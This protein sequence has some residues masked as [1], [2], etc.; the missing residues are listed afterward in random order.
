MDSA[1]ERLLPVDPPLVAYQADLAGAH[2]DAPFGPEDGLWLLAAELV[3]R[4]AATDPAMA[5]RLDGDLARL[6][7]EASR[8]ADDR[9]IGVTAG[10]HDV[11]DVPP[12]L[13]WVSALADAME[14]A[15]AHRLAYAVLAALGQVLRVDARRERALTLA[16]RAR[17]ARKL[18]RVDTARHL[19]RVV[20]RAGRL[21][22]DADLQTRALVGLAVLARRRGNYPVARTLY[23][24]A[25]RVAR[26]GATPLL[27]HVHQGLMTM[28]SVAQDFD[29]ALIH[30][31]RALRRAADD[32]LREAEI[33]GTLGA[34]ASDAGQHAAALAAYRRAAQA[35]DVV[36]VRLPAL[37]GAAQSAAWLGQRS[38][39]VDLTAEIMREPGS[40]AF[41]YERAQ[42]L[43]LL[44]RAWRRLSPET[45]GEPYRAEAD[46]L[47]RRHGYHEL[48]AMLEGSEVT[49]DAT[50]NLD[51]ARRTTW[52]APPADVALR[53][54]A[55]R[56]VAALRRMDRQDP[57]SLATV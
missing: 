36:R 56:V 42:A 34:V 3:V 21:M 4:R 8:A 43:T 47:V 40:D 6:A 7:H 5:T 35:T 52:T 27:G 11:H 54:L 25:S 41:P 55:R 29:K 31:W 32:P 10:T 23:R 57:P 2:R 15:G 39:L 19:Y 13:P 14:E 49:L 53:P 44:A 33:L 18:E 12:W 16:R 24:R 37:G 26:S 30:G 48:A 22:D 50:S 46:A 38:L 1:P 20:L 9:T 17:I 51:P 28:A 45:N